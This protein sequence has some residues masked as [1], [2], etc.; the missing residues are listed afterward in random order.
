VAPGEP[1]DP[2]LATIVADKV[3][4]LIDPHQ[5]ATP[6]PDTGARSFNAAQLLGWLCNPTPAAALA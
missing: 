1:D 6:A 4:A 5:V 3:Q 2:G